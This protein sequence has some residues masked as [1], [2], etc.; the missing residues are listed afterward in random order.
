VA[1]TV[2]HWWTMSSPHVP[3][4]QWV[5]SPGECMQRLA[6]LVSRPSA[7]PDCFHGVLAP[8][9]KLRAIVVP[10]EP[11]APARAPKPAECEGTVRK[12]LRK[13]D[14]AAHLQH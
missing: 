6:T 1:Q 8:N 11:V 2:T 7:A 13:S 12:A 14:F 5:M 10:Q 9:A 4:S 3:V